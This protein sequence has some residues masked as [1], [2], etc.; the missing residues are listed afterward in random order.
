MNK[1]KLSNLAGIKAIIYCRVS[2]VKQRIEG[3]GLE[4]QEQ[5]C[6][7]YAEERGYEVVAVFPDDTTGGGDFMKRPGIR[8][9]LAYLKAQNGQPHVVIFDDLKRF[10]RDT[11]FHWKL[12]ET[13]ATYRAVVECLNYKFEDTPEGKFVETV[14]AAQGQLEREQNSRQVVQKMKARVAS[15]FWVFRAPVG[16]KYV[17]SKTAGGKVLVPDNPLASIVKQALEGFA[18]GRFASQAEVQRFLEQSPFFPKDRKDGSIRPMTVLRLLRKAIYAGYVEAPT[19]GISLRTGQHKA[20]ISLAT[21]ETILDNLAGRK[22]GAARKDISEDF[23]LRGF[24][25]CDCCGKPMTA[26]WS[27][28]CRSHYPYY[29]CQTRGCIAKGK[30]V[31]RSLMED[32]FQKILATMQPSNELMNVATTMISDAWDARLYEAG[33]AKAEVTRQLKAIEQQIDGLLDRV[34]EAPSQLLVKAYEERITKLEREKLVLVERADQIT[35][36]PSKYDDCIE[37]ALGFLASPCKIYQNGDHATR[38]LVLKLAFAK[39]LRYDRNLG[40]RTPKIS[41]PFKVLDDLSEANGDM[42]L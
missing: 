32:G 30:S 38:R 20:L 25:L 40:Y 9:A 42:V 6:R 3:S 16:Y 2:S 11:V 10:A 33:E 23:P 4:S 39:P 19:W 37:L 15:G 27:R 29:L 24:V 7:A 34:V 28:G 12:R 8:A 1:S 21:Y 22:R 26:A 17:Q 41:F 31:P 35:P 5:R 14:F 18:N 36:P 13:F